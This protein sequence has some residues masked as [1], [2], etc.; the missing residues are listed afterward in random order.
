MAQSLQRNTESVADPAAELARMLVTMTNADRTRME[1]SV[2][3][4]VAEVVSDIG[5]NKKR[6]EQILT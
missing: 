1:E 5:N 2:A 4:V 3:K 6:E